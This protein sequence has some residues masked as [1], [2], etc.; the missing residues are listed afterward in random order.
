MNNLKNKNKPG[1]ILSAAKMLRLLAAACITLIACTSFN[2]NNPFRHTQLSKSAK[3]KNWWSNVE[4]KKYYRVD[5][6]T[7][8]FVD[9]DEFRRN[10]SGGYKYLADSINTLIQK[11]SDV[12]SRK[13]PWVAVFDN[14]KQFCGILSENMI[15]ADAGK[16]KTEKNQ[17]IMNMFLNTLHLPDAHYIVDGID[18]Y[19]DS[20]GRIKKV[21][22]ASV[23]LKGRGRNRGSQ[24][25][26]V[27]FKNGRPGLDDAG[28]LIPQQLY[29]PTEQIN[30]VPQK[31]ALNEGKIKTLETKAAKAKRAGY[32][33]SYEIHILYHGVEKRPYG[34]ENN[35]KAYDENGKMIQNVS[36]IFDNALE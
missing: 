23:I 17:V 11:V 3:V 22:C 12:N 5:F 33:V 15:V 4:Q 18:Y 20:L 10:P 8:Y 28:H 9:A 26:S 2:F 24:H 19:T 34:F 32:K 25:Y 36:G 1:N 29:G 21:F 16:E 13:G 6:S 30:Y 27:T 31:K 35:F 14:R 7:F